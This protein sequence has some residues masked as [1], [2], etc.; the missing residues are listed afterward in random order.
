MN[1]KW[2]AIGLTLFILQACDPIESG[3]PPMFQGTVQTKVQSE[4]QASISWSPGSDDLLDPDELRYGIWLAKSEDG[5]N[6]ESSAD[7][8]TRAGAISYSL[9]DLEADTEYEV[10]VRSRD[11]GNQY[12]ENTQAVTFTTSEEVAGPWRTAQEISISFDVDD[13]LSGH[14][15]SEGRDDLGLIEGSRIHWFASGNTGVSDTET[16]MTNAGATIREA[17][18]VRTD[19]RFYADLFITT[20]NGLAYYR[21]TGSGFDQVTWSIDTAIV[22][23]TLS[24]YTEDDIL[25]AFSFIESGSTARIYSNDAEAEDVDDTFFDRGTRNISNP[26]G[27]LLLIKADGDDFIDLISLGNN[28]LRIAL[29]TDDEYRFDAPTDVD[30]DIVLDRDIHSIFAGDTDEDG[31]TDIFIYERDENEAISQLYTFESQG[32][33]TFADRDTTDYASA[34]YRA[35]NLS[36]ANTDSAPDLTFIQ[37]A[38]NNIVVFYGP[39]IAYSQVGDYLGTANEVEFAQWGLYDNITGR[40]LVLVS[41]DTITV[42]LATQTSRP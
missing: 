22:E 6:L 16:A 34:T 3:E 39:S 35:P 24:F 20:D 12:S 25:V 5:V 19:T 26:N 1:F 15:F 32:D 2:T 23:D 33:G 30:T 42:L 21:N 36:H 13:L 27:T 37:S 29:G 10:V 18:L 17:Y 14:V 41:N 8:L 31:D 38:A 40:D 9:V 28:G 11:L 7:F 4:E